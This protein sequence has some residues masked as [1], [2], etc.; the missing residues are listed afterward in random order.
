M[1]FSASAV[2]LIFAASFMY[3]AGMFYPLTETSHRNIQEAEKISNQLWKEKLNTKIVI[4]N[5]DNSSNNITVY[6][7]GS[8]SLNSSRIDIILDGQLQP[9]SSYTVNPIGVWP[10]KTPINVTIG[11]AD[12]VKII[13]ANGASDYYTNNSW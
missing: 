9:S 11:A 12:R 8:I 5:W 2:V 3:M 10:P 4:T 7:N 6:N 1:G 13:A